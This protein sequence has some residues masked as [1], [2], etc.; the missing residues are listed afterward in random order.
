M[1]LMFGTK[2]DKNGNREYLEI[3][4]NG[5]AYMTQLDRVI[6]RDDFIEISESDMEK[7]IAELKIMGFEKV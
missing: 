4:T 7:L 1:I 6:A 3:S 2:K 5:N